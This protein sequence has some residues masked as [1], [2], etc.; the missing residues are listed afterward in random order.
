MIYW[1][2]ISVILLSIMLILEVSILA[3]IIDTNITQSNLIISM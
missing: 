1:K 2:H 3:Y